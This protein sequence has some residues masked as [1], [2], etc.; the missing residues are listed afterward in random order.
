VVVLAWP[1]QGDILFYHTDRKIARISNKT[2]GPGVY[3]MG[4]FLKALCEIKHQ[5]QDTK[6][7][8]RLHIMAHS[9]GN[10]VFRYIL[11]EIYKNLTPEEITFL[12]DE[13]ILIATD[14]DA[15]SFEEEYKLMSLPQFAHR[16]SVYFNSEDFPLWISDFFMGNPT[17]LGRKGVF[18]PQNI[19]HNVAIINCE[20]IVLGI[21]EHNYHK[22]TPIV[23]C[24]IA[25]VLNGIKS[26]NI[27]GR[28]YDQKTNTYR[29]I[30]MEEFIKKNI[31]PFSD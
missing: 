22:Y 30:E 13:V 7:C 2:L 28:V 9:M 16:V 12:F 18:K 26:K 1:S 4:Q 25:Y 11:Q 19:P 6:I 15:N 14:E 5:S 17:R 10:Y 21:F 8:G 27:P 29:L 24:D 31:H 20:E 23:L 3:Q